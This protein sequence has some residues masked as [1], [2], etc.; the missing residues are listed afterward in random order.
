MYN[1]SHQS[2]STMRMSRNNEDTDTNPKKDRVVKRK[3]QAQLPDSRMLWDPVHPGPLANQLKVNMIVLNF[4][5]EVEWD[6]EHPLV[7]Q[8]TAQHPTETIIFFRY[9][10]D[11]QIEI[12]KLQLLEDHNI[13][14]STVHKKVNAVQ[15]TP[16]TK[17]FYLLNI[18]T[19]DRFRFEVIGCFIQ[20]HYRS[21]H[22]S[23][24]MYQLG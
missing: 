7:Q 21:G 10:G 9:S 5:C 2:T 17:S 8:H 15:M 12:R 4:A 23:G 22:M 18:N 16:P 3:L 13:N 24:V 1:S 20:P 19:L 11:K 6:S 14:W